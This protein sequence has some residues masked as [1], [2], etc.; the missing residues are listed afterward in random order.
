MVTCQAQKAAYMPD[1]DKDLEAYEDMR[2]ELE[3]HS[4]GKWILVHDRKLVGTY[5]SF[6]HAASDA[7]ST[8]GR[9]PY[10]IRQVG[11][12]PIVLPAAV[13]FFQHPY[14]TTKMRV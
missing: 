10:L 8:F 2:A 6:E 1:L 9:G 13:A 11:A 12:Q 3:A 7:V 4:M 14:G 5:D